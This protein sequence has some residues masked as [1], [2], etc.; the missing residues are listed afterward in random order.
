MS[1]QALAERLELWGF[2]EDVMIF[3]DGS[4]G[5][6]MSVTPVD[7]AAW[8]DERINGYRT[9]I[10]TFLNGLPDDL[11]VQFIQGIARGSK[12]IINAHSELR[13]PEVNET[14]IRLCDERTRRLRALDADGVIPRH[15][16]TIL[17]RRSPVSALVRKPKLFG[18]SKH[19]QSLTEERLNQEI[20][21]TKQLREDMFRSIS[22]LD[23]EPHLLSASEITEA[24]Y[25]QWNPDRRVD[26]PDFT[27]D[28]IRAGLL[29]TDAFV[30]DRGFSLGG[31]HHRVLSLKLMPDCSY[32]AM[33]AQLREL[34]FDSKLF[35]TIHVPNQ[36]KEIEALQ[37]QRR[38]AFAMVHGKR[39]GVRDIESQAKLDDLETLLEN[40]IAQGE[41]VFHVSLNILL[42]A[43]SVDEL[44]RQV[45]SAMMTIREL[46]GAEGMEE[47]LA[48]F[49]IFCGFAVPHGR[50]KERVRR[51]KTSNL[52][53][54][55]PLYG[56]WPG[57]KSPSILLRSRLGSLVGFDPFT[58]E[59][60]N[61]NQ[62]VSGGS[63]AGKSFMTNILL[64]H[65]LKERPRVFIIDIGGSY[66]KLCVELMAKEEGEQRLPKLERAVIEDAIQQVLSNGGGDAR[67][68]KLRDA[69]LQHSD[70][71]IARYGRIL[72]PWC[73]DTS[74]GRFV[75]RP[76]TI[77]LESP[78][79]CFDLKGMEAYPDL[80]AVCLLLITDYVWR[81]IQRDRGSKKVVVFDECWRLLENDAG[82]AFLG[83]VFRTF[84][85]YYAS[86]I[87]ISQNI[88]DFAKSRIAGAI[89][90]NSA[91]KWIL[92]Q[93]GAD[94]DRLKSVLHLN[95]NEMT[96]IDSLH[97]E[98]GVYSEAYLMAQDDRSVVVIES[99]P[100]EYWIATSDP[101]ELAAIDAAVAAEPEKSRLEIIS[102]LAKKH[103]RGLLA[104]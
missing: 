59:L 12:Q 97:Q 22:S 80:Q 39:S 13:N 28:D 51:M 100:L 49:D 43:T 95:D 74:Y 70:P 72:G 10:A 26:K 90:P 73:G 40:M 42:R 15:D 53:D 41:K 64:L 4:F 31:Y 47:S 60:T 20:A 32:A 69:L 96:L 8:D 78:I 83:E 77:K 57:H 5:F 33:A 19:F 9:K 62:I 104:T 86:A 27:T 75:D 2:E 98:R 61:A 91:V 14:V 68:S 52:A 79:I 85:K 103:S 1:Q 18:R 92:R 45:S 50:A 66:K 23:F 48:A 24:V 46:G 87:A 44:E 71:Q 36:Q 6:G 102:G 38:L 94:Q 7:V 11:D 34:P 63:G 99:T 21:V 35:L 17:F 101:R 58:R 76:T 84:R 30:S 25:R 56:P 81:E 3:S 55:L 37:T 54:F 88:D 93:K 29:F 16:L 67:L 82:A 89:M 65:L